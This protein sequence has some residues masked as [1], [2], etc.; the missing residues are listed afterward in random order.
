MH[1]VN[2]IRSILCPACQV[3]VDNYQKKLPVSIPTQEHASPTKTWHERGIALLDALEMTLDH[4]LPNS[5]FQNKIEAFGLAIEKKFAPLHRFNDWLNQNEMGTWYR[6]L[7]L[8]LIKLPMRVARNII[9]L[10]YSIIKGA[11]NAALHPLKAPI[12]LAKLLVR[13][14]H[15]LTKPETWSKMGAGMLAA[16]MGQSFVTGNPI[17]LIGIGIGAAM[18]IG[19]ISVGVLKRALQAEKGHRFHAA[20]DQ[21]LLQAK[22]LPEAALTGFVF[23]LMMG[24]I[25]NAIRQSYELQRVREAESLAKRMIEDLDLYFSAPRPSW[26]FDPSTGKVVVDASS[27]MGIFNLYVEDH[28]HILHPAGTLFNALGAGTAAAVILVQEK[29]EG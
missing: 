16:S 7:A 27:T 12:K 8:F 13:L 4:H 19:G 17:S 14:V 26:S 15:E 25:Q 23:G 18:L 3:E 11:L 6:R 22:E 1:S 5:V 29:Q 10:L 9:S 2:N 20:V 21:F 28:L 24:G